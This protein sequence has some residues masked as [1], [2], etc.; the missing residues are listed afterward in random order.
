MLACT[1]FALFVLLPRAGQ[2]RKVCA[3]AWLIGGLNCRV[4]HCLSVVAN[5]RILSAKAKIL[6]AIGNFLFAKGSFLK[7]DERILTADR[8]SLNAHAKSPL[9]DGSFLNA[10]GG[11]H[12]ANGN[13]LFYLVKKLNNKRRILLE[14]F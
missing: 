8:K 7:S 5:G 9:S 6:L 13:S 3:N 1:L 14:R 4:A 11:F 2:K 12:V 10:E